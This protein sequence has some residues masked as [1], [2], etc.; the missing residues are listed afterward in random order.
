MPCPSVREMI[1]MQPLLAFFGF[2]GAVEMLIVLFVFM[3]LF[4]SRL[5][6]VMRS[7]GQGVVE[8]KKGV[9][10]IEDQSQPSETSGGDQSSDA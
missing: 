1:L 8:F 5:P 2:P 6:S 7:L 3:L 4:G 9:K 10:G